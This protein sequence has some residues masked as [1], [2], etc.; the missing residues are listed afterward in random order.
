MIVP[1]QITNT[2]I[3]SFIGNLVFM[4]WSSKVLFKNRKE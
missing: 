1:T 2:E 3:F 4:L